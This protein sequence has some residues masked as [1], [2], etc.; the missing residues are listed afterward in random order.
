MWSSTSRTRG[1]IRYA[2]SAPLLAPVLT[3]APTGAEIVATARGGPPVLG[4]PFAETPTEQLGNAEFGH[5]RPDVGAG[6]DHTG[7]ACQRGRDP[8]NRAVGRRRWQGDD[9]PTVGRKRGASKGTGSG[10]GAMT[11]TELQREAARLNIDGRSKMGKAQ[12]IRA[13]SQKRRA[14]S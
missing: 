1:P 5:D 12:L 13:V 7:A 10:A 14:R 3:L 9:R 6:G 11:V 4:G 8:R 2:E